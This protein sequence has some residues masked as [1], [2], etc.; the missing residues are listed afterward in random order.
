VFRGQIQIDQK[1]NIRV[2]LTGSIFAFGG[3][4]GIRAEPIAWD[5]EAARGTVSRCPLALT[6]ARK[7]GIRH[8][9]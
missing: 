2:W 3:I 9:K 1:S 6:A 8:L 4:A 7:F 5:T